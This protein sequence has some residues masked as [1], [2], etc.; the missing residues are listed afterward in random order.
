MHDAWS[1][2][3]CVSKCPV[4]GR[5][6]MKKIISMQVPIRDGDRCK[7]IPYLSA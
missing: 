5:R 3:S 2:W 7:R 4:H 6:Q 1:M